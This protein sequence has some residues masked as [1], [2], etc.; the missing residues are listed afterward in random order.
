MAATEMAPLEEYIQSLGINEASD[1]KTQEFW[2]QI[3][4]DVPGIISECLSSFDSAPYMARAFSNV[5]RSELSR[6]LQAHLKVLFTH[7]HDLA[8]IMRARENADFFYRQKVKPLAVARLYAALE[9]GFSKAAAQ[10]FWLRRGRVV[11][12][13]AN[14]N[15]LFALDL[16]IIQNVYQRHLYDTRGSGPSGDFGSMIEGLQQNMDR[17]RDQVGVAIEDLH[18]LARSMAD[19]AKDTSTQSTA[20]HAAVQ[21][22]NGN[23]TAVTHTAEELSTSIGEV[24]D[25]VSASSEVSRKAMQEAERTTALVRGLSD[26][27]QKIGEVVTLINDIA[28]KT[29]LL[30]LNATIEAARAGEVGK[31][32]AVVASEVKMLANQTASATDE[33][34]SQVGSIQTATTESVDAIETIAS[35]IGQINEIADVV[36]SA[37][38]DQSAATG[39]ISDSVSDA[40]RAVADASDRSDKIV[41]V[42]A[43][44]DSN[45]QSVLMAVAGL[46]RSMTDLTKSL[47]GFTENLKQAG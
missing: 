31:G 9:N 29:N 5:D 26:A 36:S 21:T 2:S 20:V 42:S 25:R 14:I 28:S 15:R 27:A 43:S 7:R 39:R 22:A 18:G 41:D 32:F 17:V 46:S 8:F 12:T 11:E 47:D 10:R 37:V 19:S 35:I 38:D 40:S 34:A 6:V 4:G 45:A 30:A 13:I 3:Q 44:V 24:R 16:N 23:V 1:R 33:I